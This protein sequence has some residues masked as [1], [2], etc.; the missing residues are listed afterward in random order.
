MLLRDFSSHLAA[1]PWAERAR[2]TCPGQAG[3][4]EPA[5]GRACHEFRFWNGAGAK[6][7]TTS[8]K[9]RRCEKYT[10]LAGVGGARVPAHAIEHLNKHGLSTIEPWSRWTRRD[11]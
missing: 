3:W 4:G 7:G 11:A 1:D 6:V 8:H 2:I 9:P 5:I 10:Q